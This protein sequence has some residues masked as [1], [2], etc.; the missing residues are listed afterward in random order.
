MV[1]VVHIYNNEDN[2]DKKDNE[3]NVNIENNNGDGILKR[4]WGFFINHVFV[5]VFQ[6][7]P[8]PPKYALELRDYVK[9]ILL[10]F[11]SLF[12]MGFPGDYD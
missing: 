8:G 10:F 1:F 12:T 4:L 5:G 3:D 9:N 6:N 11:S 2:K 7:D